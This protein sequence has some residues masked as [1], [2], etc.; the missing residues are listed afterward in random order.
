M[1]EG[2]YCVQLGGPI[3]ARVSADH[4]ASKE[5]KV[6][7]RLTVCVR[8]CVC[9]THVCVLLHTCVWVAGAG[10]ARN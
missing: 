8:A 4:L 6:Q 3:V 5:A 7:V 9:G 1:C 2:Y 10:A